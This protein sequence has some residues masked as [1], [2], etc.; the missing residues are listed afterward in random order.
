MMSVNRQFW[1]LCTA[2]LFSASLV[3]PAL[4]AEGAPLP[5]VTFA[6]V[7]K[8]AASQ[9]LQYLGRI[10]SP[11]FVQVHTRTEGFVKTLNFKEGQMV[12]AGD[13]LFEL[14][15]AVHQSAVDQAQAQVASAQASL[16]LTEVLY[17]RLTPLARTR[18]VSQTDADRA[19][20]DRDVARAALA[21]AE[22]ALRARE[23]ELSFT[24]I[25]APIAGRVGTTDISVGSFVNAASPALIDIAQLD[26]IR[27]V[28][29]VRERDFISATLGDDK[30]PL[31]LFGKDFAP[32]LRLANGKIFP[33]LGKFD[34]IG[35]RINEQTGTVEVRARFPNPKSLLLPGGVVDVTLTAQ[36]P[37]TLPAV[38]AAAL[39]QDLEGFFVLLL[40]QDDTVAVRRVTLGPQMDQEF[41]VSTGLVA[42]DKVIVDGLQRVRPGSQVRPVPA[43]PVA[44]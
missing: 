29:A 7:Q 20:A 15:P 35:N 18:A 13:V 17:A 40:E 25:T 36:E 5:A 26:P 39:Q 12:K 9:P 10:E 24:R 22:A 3:A 28:I 4:G 21:Q 8:R 2:L 6:V 1:C 44:Q 37:P 16:A 32:Q 31:D 42:G 30:L 41:I 43:T 38:P 19:L 33:D 27:V 14:D 23:L 11:N 34:S